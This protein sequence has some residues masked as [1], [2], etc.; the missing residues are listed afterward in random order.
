MTPHTLSPIPGLASSMAFTS[1]S[2]RRTQ[3]ADII[4]NRPPLNV[5]VDAATRPAAAGVRDARR[6]RARAR[7][8][9]ARRSASIS[10][11]A[12]TS[13]LHG[14]LAGARLEARL[15]HRR[16]G[17]LRQAGDRRQP[18]L[19]LRRRLRTL[20]GLRFPHRV[21]N[22]CFYALPEQ[23]LGQ[24]PGSGGS[25]RLQK[26]DRHHPHQGHRDALEAHPGEAGAR[27]GHRDRMRARRRTRSGDRR[28]GRRT[29]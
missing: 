18:R 29:A 21:G 2:T 5:V 26:I 9:A 1:R 7:H 14:S 8:R 11:A 24:I 28:A 20:A 22:D 13:G 27:L 19:L 6:G 10:P 16:A 12:A 15:E 3:R 25:A 23:K 4:L 17:A